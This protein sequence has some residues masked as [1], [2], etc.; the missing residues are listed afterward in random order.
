MMSYSLSQVGCSRALV[1][2]ST[3]RTV[4][5][6]PF[7]DTFLKVMEKQVLDRNDTVCSSYAAAMGYVARSATDEQ[8]LKTATFVKNLYFDAETDRNRLIAAEIVQ[9]VGKHATDRFNNVASA[10]LPLVFVGRQDE[11]EEVKKLFQEIWDDNA[12]GP[13][14]ASLYL[15]EI[16]ALASNHLSARQWNLKH[17]AALS[18]SEAVKAVAAT[19][20]T[21]SDADAQK[22]WPALKIALAEKSW[23]GKEHVLEGFVAF[24]QNASE[25]WKS[26]K[27][28]AEDVSKVSNAAQTLLFSCIS[29]DGLHVRGLEPVGEHW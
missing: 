5:F 19:K 21:I 26:R 16:I 18:V 22:L 20:S 28:V 24:V 27:E 1:S 2:L 23:D 11:K 4:L 14:A 29:S 10:Y 8:L 7:A 25:F 15:D 17:T 12:G 9:A 3:R 6:R 13:R